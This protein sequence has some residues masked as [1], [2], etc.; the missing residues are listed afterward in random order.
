[1]A[2]LDL[3][4][5]ADEQG[6]AVPADRIGAAFEQVDR[7]IV[8]MLREHERRDRARAGAA[9]AVGLL[10]RADIGVEFAE[11]HGRASCRER[12]CQYVWVPVDAGIVQKKIQTLADS[13]RADENYN[14]KIEE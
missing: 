2:F 9:A 13:T 1:M 3:R 11:Q 7:D 6:I 5:L 12:V 14:H 8:A 4:V 10:P